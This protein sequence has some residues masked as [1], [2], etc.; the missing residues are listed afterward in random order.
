MTHERAAVPALQYVQAVA[1]DDQEV[2]AAVTEVQVEIVTQMHKR[3]RSSAANSMTA[4][5]AKVH[6]SREGIAFVTS[7][8]AATGFHNVKYDARGKHLPYKAYAGQAAKGS[9][10][11]SFATAEEAALTYARYVG[12]TEEHCISGQGRL[13]GSEA[14]RQQART[15]T[16]VCLRRG[17]AGL[18]NKMRANAYARAA[19]REAFEPGDGC[20]GPLCSADYRPA[21]YARNQS[22]C[23]DEIESGKRR[24]LCWPADVHGRSV[25]CEQ[26]E[27]LQQAVEAAREAIEAPTRRSRPRANSAR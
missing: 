8:R 16:L 21:R 10:L 12:N 3:K 15:D 9:F 27:G 14:A 22:E 24:L 13:A 7:H 11:G 23:A 5:E 19:G 20:A 6:A 25:V 17:C 26:P 2:D 4:D 1:V 18:V